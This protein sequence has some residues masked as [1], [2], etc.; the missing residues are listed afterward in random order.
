MCCL[1]WR[2]LV[3]V[4]IGVS[5]LDEMLGGGFPR[6]RI[7]LVRGGPGSGKTTLCMQFVLDGVRKNEQGIYVTLEEP[8]DLV[9]ENMRVFGWNLEDYEEKGLL[10]LVDGSKLVSKDFGSGGY[11]RESKLVMKGI[12]DI[13][14]RSVDQFGA[15]RL[16]ID[17]I[18]SAVIQQRFPTDK[19]FEIFELISTLRKLDCTSV[20]SSEFSSSAGEGDFYVEEY[21]ADGVIVLSK[22]LHDF[23]L[24]K[25][26]RIEKMRG[27]K[28]DDQPRKYEINDN[29]IVVYHT[30]SVSLP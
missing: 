10:R 15:K 11:N 13:L 8:V 26:A 3:R 18:T 24:I 23:K 30:E 2:I 9:R 27:T 20:I 22:S 19:R 7:V 17:P 28:H 14:R 6:N 5:G 12:T 16:A 21:L 1:E 4:S 29:G 25:T